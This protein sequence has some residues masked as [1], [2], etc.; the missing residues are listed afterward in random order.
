MKISAIAASIAVLGLAA[1][2]VGASE[3][4]ETEA[5]PVPAEAQSLRVVRDKQTGK[6]RAPTADELK[7]M[8]AAERAERKARG[9]PEVTESQPLVVTRHAS[10]M[11]SA[12]L[13]PEYMMTLEGER[14]PDGSLHRGHPDGTTHAHAPLA[15]DNRPTE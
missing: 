14:Q 2:A 15:R 11:L 13:G 6:L 8:Q 5:S 4:T 1:G 9:L 10:G 12:K 3:P 7:A